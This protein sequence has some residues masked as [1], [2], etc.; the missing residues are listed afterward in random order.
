[1]ATLSTVATRSLSVGI[2]LHYGREVRHLDEL[3]N[4]ARLLAE[5]AQVL[6]ETRRL[7]VSA[8]YALAREDRKSVV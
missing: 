1:M 2:D 4:P 3:L 8:G 7:S 5:P 6:P